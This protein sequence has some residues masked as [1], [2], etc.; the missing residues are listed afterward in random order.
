MT[1]S[2]IGAVGSPARRA[3]MICDRFISV[4]TPSSKMTVAAASCATSASN[5]R[6]DANTKIATAA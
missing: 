5:M 3:R 2:L 6:Q 1:G 4:N